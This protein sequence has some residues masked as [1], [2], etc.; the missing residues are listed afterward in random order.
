MSAAGPSQGTNSAPRGA[1][2]RREPQAWGDHMRTAPASVS[3]PRR[4]HEQGLALVIAMLVAALAAAVA[5][6]LATGQTQWS[7][8]VSHRRDQVQAQSIALAGVQWA[9]Q[10]LDQDARTTPTDHLGEPWAFPLPATPV[11]NGFVEG[12]IVDAQGFLNINDL[13]SA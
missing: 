1:A 8:Q 12:R 3:M 4:Q 5:M 7:A 13:A 11:E 9:R 2:Q 10:V 6:S